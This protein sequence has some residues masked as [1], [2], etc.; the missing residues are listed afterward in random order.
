MQLFML[1]GQISAHIYYMHTLNQISIKI[2][3]SIL[4]SIKED[5]YNRISLLN[6]N[7]INTYN[8]FDCII[9]SATKMV[10]I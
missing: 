1:F 6:N 3:F 8:R 7:L 5:M 4:F 10:Q 9:V 2:Q